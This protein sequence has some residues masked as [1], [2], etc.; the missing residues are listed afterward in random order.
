MSHDGR[1]AI[2]DFPYCMS[3]ADAIESLIRENYDSF[4]L[5]VGCITVCA[6]CVSHGRFKIFDSH[7]RD[8]YGMTHSQGTCVLLELQSISNL[9]EYIHSLYYHA[10]DITFE[11]KGSIYDADVDVVFSLKT[12]GTLSCTLNS[13]RQHLQNFIEGNVSENT[14]FS[15]WISSFCISCVFHRLPKGKIQYFICALHENKG[16][17]TFQ[18]ITDTFSLMQT[19]CDLVM[20]KDSSELQYQIQFVACS[21]SQLSNT[22]RQSIIRKHKSV[23]KKRENAK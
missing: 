12:H 21:N 10:R 13:R 23:N 7:S 8:T 19:V 3:L 14:G 2:E 20:E 16:Q 1:S 18:K 5:T 4:I 22:K 15:L 9:I 11:V 6:Y 17:H